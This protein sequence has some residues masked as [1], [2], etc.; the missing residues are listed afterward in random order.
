M[1][2]PVQV[3][4]KT[5][6]S[7]ARIKE[8]L[9]MPNLIEI[10]QNSYAW[11]LKE[12]IREM[13]NDI[14]P[15]QDFTGNLVLEI[16]DYKLD[17]PKYSVPECRERDVTYNAPMRVKARLIN[18]ETGE[19]K[20][21]EVF[22]GDFPLMT[23]KGTFIINGA[24]RVVVSQLVRSPSVYYTE[25]IDTSGKKILGRRLSLTEVPG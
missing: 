4:R 7:F 16:I 17:E 6:E 10:Q 20:E 21:Q 5:R 8:V 15:I 18:K 14:S 12:G 22:M 24:E 3:G 1:R 25:E 9:K 11:F 19:V 13:F 2:Q 23:E